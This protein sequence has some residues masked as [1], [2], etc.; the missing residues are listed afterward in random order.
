VN[1]QAKRNGYGPLKDA[2]LAVLPPARNKRW[3]QP[4]EMRYLR[5]ELKSRSL[6][7]ALQWHFMTGE[8][9]RRKNEING[10]WEYA[11]ANGKAD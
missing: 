5:P 10:K 4:A 8:L 11:R 1:A 7:P 6:Y 3:M 2:I 9:A